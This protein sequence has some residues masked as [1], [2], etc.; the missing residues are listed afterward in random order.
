MSGATFEGDFL[1]VAD[2]RMIGLDLTPSEAA[3]LDCLPVVGPDIEE[4]FHHLPSLRWSEFERFLKSGVPARALVY[5][6]LPARARV[7]FFPDRPLFDFAED[8][9]EDGAAPAFVFVARD[10]FG[11]ACD[12]VAWAPSEARVAAWLGRASM[13]GLESL[14]APR[15]MHEGALPVCETPLEWL[16]AERRAVVILDST[17]ARWSLFRTNLIVSDVAYGCRLREALRWPAPQIF[18][19]GQMRSA[20]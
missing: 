2:P 1:T 15:I 4:R 18:V 19:E 10:E 9:G 12:L 13:L 5:P 7:V 14:R 6:E 3:L 17:R 20:A 16:R 8:V 11:D